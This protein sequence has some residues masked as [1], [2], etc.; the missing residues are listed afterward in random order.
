MATVD[1]I[2]NFKAVQPFTNRPEEVGEVILVDIFLGNHSI[3][4]LDM[5]FLLRQLTCSN[6]NVGKHT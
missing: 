6:V 2:L 1:F 5:V 3:K 4:I